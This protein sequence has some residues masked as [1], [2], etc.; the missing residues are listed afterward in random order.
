MQYA[1]VGTKFEDVL[2]WAK[3]HEPDTILHPVHEPG[4]RISETCFFSKYY[5]H[6]WQEP[7][8]VGIKSVAAKSW[9]GGGCMFLPEWV[10]EAIFT[11]DMADVDANSGITAKRA[12]EILE[13]LKDKG[14]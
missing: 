7:V 1:T 11:F 10:T 4:K 13:G 14:E 12:V 6:R 8:T 3:S 9:D 2:E 5:S